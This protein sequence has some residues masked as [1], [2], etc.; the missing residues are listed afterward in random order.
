MPRAERTSIPRAYIL[1]GV[2]SRE[3]C[4]LGVR[5]GARTGAGAG[6]GHRGGPPIG[7]DP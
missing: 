7:W 1:A 4:D 2:I 6:R 3:G 5:V